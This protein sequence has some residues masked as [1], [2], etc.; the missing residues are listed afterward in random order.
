MIPE[1]QA[2]NAGPSTSAAAPTAAAQAH[3][4]SQRRCLVKVRWLF[5]PALDALSA[6][7]GQQPPLPPLPC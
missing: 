7:L 2:V 5:K 3:A 4:L 1:D 6:A